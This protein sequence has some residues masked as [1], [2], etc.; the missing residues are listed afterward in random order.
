MRQGDWT[1]QEIATLK[2]CRESGMFAPAISRLLPG[3]TVKAIKTKAERL[4]FWLPTHGQGENASPL[5]WQ[6]PKPEDDAEIDRAA[7]LREYEEADADWSLL[8]GGRVF[9]NHGQPGA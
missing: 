9:T 2:R 7:N 5:Y 1:E 6:E 8:L 3:R 4:G